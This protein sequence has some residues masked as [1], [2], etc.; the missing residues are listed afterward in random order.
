MITKKILTT[1][2][3]R[4]IFIDD[5]IKNNCTYDH[6][7]YATGYKEE[8]DRRYFKTGMRLH[9]MRCFD[10]KVLFSH[11]AVEGEGYCMR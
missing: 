7:E 3:P 11:D 8:S 5:C 4:I 10:Y 6:S 1:R 9:G 2:K